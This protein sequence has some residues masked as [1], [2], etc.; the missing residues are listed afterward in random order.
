MKLS[1]H[2]AVMAVGILVLSAGVLAPLGSSI[3]EVQRSVDDLST[4]TGPDVPAEVELQ[5][6]M[7]R[8]AEFEAALASR[9]VKL[10]SGTPEATNAFESALADQ[11]RLSGLRRVSMDS[12]PGSPISGFKTFTIDLSVEG[13]ASQLRAL[14]AGLESL[15]WVNRVLRLELKKGDSVRKVDLRIALLLETKS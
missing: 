15:P 11:V 8:I 7:E 10:C 13:T 4:S 6:L 12:G 9:P 5:I 1:S 14:L 2:V 3:K